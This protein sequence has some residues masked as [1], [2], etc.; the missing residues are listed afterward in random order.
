M[1]IAKKEILKRDFVNKIEKGVIFGYSEGFFIVNE[2]L[3]F[4]LVNATTKEKFGPYLYTIGFHNGYAA[5]QRVGF[6]DVYF[7]SV[8]DKKGNE[9]AEF[10]TGNYKNVYFSDGYA[11]IGD[12]K[13][14][15]ITGKE[16]E[17]KPDDETILNV[18]DFKNGRA[19]VTFSLF[20]K[21][22][23]YYIDKE[24]KRINKKIYDIAEEFNND[25]AVAG[26]NK[27]RF[28]IDKKGNTLFKYDL[29]KDKMK[30]VSRYSEGLLSYSENG[31]W[32]YL[33]E[34]G[35][36]AIKSKFKHSKKFSD[37]VIT[38]YENGSI[39]MMDKEENKKLLLSR[40]QNHGYDYISE[41]KNGYALLYY[42]RLNPL[43]DI[44]DKEG[45][46][47]KLSDNIEL[48]DDYVVLSDSQ[49]FIKLADL[50]KL[51][52]EY[53]IVI[54]RN[55][56]E[57]IKSFESEEERDKY[58]DMLIQ[59]KNSAVDLS[60]KVYNEYLD[61][62]LEDSNETKEENPTRETYKVKVKRIKRK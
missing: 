22:K 29:N 47:T 5:V 57:I 9:V 55:N 26:K 4:Y 44:V 28:I 48:Y 53:Q 23:Y 21:E 42:D 14:I 31:I 17:Y 18:S 54:T 27:K 10:S 36:V 43:A 40:E 25:R 37:G 34:N 49:S 19:I 61:K 15:D 56:K 12:K 30:T 2:G 6:Q 35:N 41:F 50:K 32:G 20:G 7:W 3:N 33:N 13:F 51:K 45:N 60:R 16:I 24:F 62:L 46:I 52:K 59:E 8:I 11:K 58:F 1:H 39:Y 38:Y